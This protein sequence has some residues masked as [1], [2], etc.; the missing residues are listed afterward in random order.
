[1][2]PVSEAYSCRAMAARRGD[3]VRER[4]ERRRKEG[5]GEYMLRQKRERKGEGARIGCYQGGVGVLTS[6]R[7][8]VRDCPGWRP[9]QPR[10]RRVAVCYGVRCPPHH[11]HNHDRGNNTPTTRLPRPP[12]PHAPTCAV[13][14]C[15][16]HTPCH[17]PLAAARTASLCSL[18][19]LTL[20]TLYVFFVLF[21]ANFLFC[22]PV[23][24]LSPPS[25]P[26]DARPSS[27]S[28]AHHSPTTDRDDNG[29]MAM[30]CG[31]DVA[32]RM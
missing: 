29:T 30:T 5:E 4:K 22:G 20:G 1:M 27:P 2:I 12:P 17:V 19:R 25:F 32:T 16:L 9:S 7:G 18:R 24:V 26:T 8:H 15:S 10:D 11:N 14:L 3:V 31:N 23:T 28:R 21:S 13:S 6:T